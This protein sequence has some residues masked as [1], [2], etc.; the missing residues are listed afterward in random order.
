M[1]NFKLKNDIMDI[2][3]DVFSL[4]QMSEEN[5]IVM[6]LIQEHNYYFETYLICIVLPCIAFIILILTHWVSLLH[7]EV[8]T[9]KKQHFLLLSNKLAV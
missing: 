4:I 1:Y 2:Q 5:D 7:N 9:L 6:K 3:T 8:K